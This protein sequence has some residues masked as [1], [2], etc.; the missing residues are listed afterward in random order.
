M[1][2]ARRTQQ[3]ILKFRGWVCRAPE[4]F[5]ED[6]EY[7]KLEEMFKLDGVARGMAPWICQE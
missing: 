3:F 1:R 4:M 7:S 5:D 2:R 6:E